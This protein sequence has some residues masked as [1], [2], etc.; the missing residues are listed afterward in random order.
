MLLRSCRFLLAVLLLCGPVAAQ[1]TEPKTPAEFFGRMKFEMDVGNYSTAAKY[2]EGLLKINPSEKDLVDLEKA[3]GTTAFLKLRNIPRWADP[4]PPGA[5]EATKKAAAA[6][7]AAA[8]KNVET[9]ITNVN[10]AVKKNLSDPDRIRKFVRNLTVGKDEYEYAMGELYR[11][12]T[13]AIPYILDELRVADGEQRVALLKALTQFGPEVTPPLIAGLDS[14]VPALQI[15][16]I[17]VLRKRGALEAIPSLYWIL[18]NSASPPPLR[19]AA[20]EA[21]VYF[22]RLPADRLPSPRAA[23]TAEAERYYRHQVQFVD[24]KGVVI[25]RWDNDRVTQGWKDK[26][27]IPATKAEEYYV[28]RYATQALALDPAYEPAQLVLA[29]LVLDKNYEEI[30]QAKSLADV[31]P[32]VYQMLS[33]ISP[34]VLT[35]VLERGLRDKRSNV[36]LGALRILGNQGEIR[37]TIPREVAQPPLSQALNYPDPRVQLVAVETQLKIPGPVPAA[38]AVRVVDILKRALAADSINKPMAR[39]LVG[40]FDEDRSAVI[41]DQ[42]RKIGLDPVVVRSGRAGIR[43]LQEASDIDAILMDA[44]L[45]DPGLQNVLAQLKTDRNARALPVVLTAEPRSY[46]RWR[47]YLEKNPQARLLPAAATEDGLALKAAIQGALEAPEHRPLTAEEVQSH[48]ERAIKALA[49]LARKEIA[50]YDVRPADLAVFD[51]LRT[52]KLSVDGQLAAVAVI[53]TLPGTRPQAELLDA[54]VR[55]VHPKEVRIAA[56]ETLVKHLQ[57]FGLVL[58]PAQTAPIA[59]LAADPKLDPALRSSVTALLGALNPSLRLSGERLQG[60]QPEI[61]PPVPVPPVPPKDK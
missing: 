60:Y 50:G 40:Y 39:V 30:G 5:A 22:T 42:L 41:A 3:E 13:M 57:Q 49:K 4:V 51:V 52:N 18:G 6:F 56:A 25:W 26:P 19:A 29:S 55:S 7:E 36:I 2:L 45:P 54:L 48:A 15:D 44:D 20:R 9:L 17:A 23:L 24:P 10:E 59:Q 58:R 34:D 21:L 37:A 32:G 61:V 35:S 33:A 53:G 38:N 14:G 46:E 11:S 16:L 47:F 27:T 43:R 31:R 28:T 1:F 12:G 8:R